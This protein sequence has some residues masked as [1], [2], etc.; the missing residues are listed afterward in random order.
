[1]P[2]ARKLSPDEFIRLRNENWTYAQIA[3]EYGLTVSGVQ[4]M[5]QSLG[6]VRQQSSHKAAIPWKLRKEHKNTTVANTLRHLSHLSMG[7]RLHESERLHKWWANS[8]IN[9]ANE[10]LDQGKDIDYDENKGPNDFSKQGGFYLKEA[11]PDNWHL[12]KLMQRVISAQTR[13]L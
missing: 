3:G 8:A 9:K 4:Q 10:I 2:N 7:N 13:K 11:D 1:M 12:K 5:A 6:L